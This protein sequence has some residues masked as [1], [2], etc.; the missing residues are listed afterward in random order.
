M[1]RPPDKEG[2][3]ALS[4]RDVESSNAT[5][6]TLFGGSRQKSWMMGAGTPV[7]PTPRTSISKASAL[8]A[9]LA[10]KSVASVLPSPA[11]SDEASPV[12]A[13][14][15]INR[16][17]NDTHQEVRNGDPI[18]PSTTTFTPSRQAASEPVIEPAGG[19]PPLDSSSGPG[20]SS[21]RSPN[22]SRR[23]STNPPPFTDIPETVM[24]IP[25]LP[26]S[27]LLPSERQD[28]RHTSQDLNSPRQASAPSPVQ[29]GTPTSQYRTLPSPR[30]SSVSGLG[31]STRPA[32]TQ[33]QTNNLDG[34]QQASQVSVDTIHCVNEG[35]VNTSSAARV[36]DAR[37]PNLAQSN[38]S[39][40][41][42]STSTT[43]NPNKR[44]RTQVNA[45][46]SLKGRVSLI[47]K[48]IASAGGLQNLNT[49]LER[50]RFALLTDACRNEDPF[51]VALHQVFCVW[52]LNQQEVIIIPGYP[53]SNI[54]QAAF[55]ILGALIRDN[56]Q[57]APVHKIWFAQFP[58]PLG[59]LL[60]V[61][62]VYRQSI[63]D[64][65]VF[66]ERLTVEWVS[67]STEW[68]QR[69]YPP[70]VDELVSRLGLLSPTLQSV[71]FTAT[72]RNLGIRDED[73][74]TR[75]E[76]LFRRD[77]Q[78][79]QALSARVNTAR[80]PTAK[81]VQERNTALVNEYLTLHNHVIQR[82]SS[83]AISGSPLLRGPTPVLASNAPRPQ[84][85]SIPH[86]TSWQQDMPGPDPATTWQS[87]A[88]N[89]QGILRTSNGPPNPSIAGRPPSVGSQQ[90][91][92]DTPSPTLLQGLSMNSP[93]QQGFP[94][95]GSG[96]NGAPVQS[97]PQYPQGYPGYIVNGT[98]QQQSS[99]IDPNVYNRN[100]NTVQYQQQLLPQYPQPQ[101]PQY[102]TQQY[103]PAQG[104]WPQHSVQIQHA[105]MMRQQQQRQLEQQ[106]FAMHRAAQLRNES[107]DPQQ[108][109]VRNNS[110]SS[111]GRRTPTG[112]PSPRISGPPALGPGR[113]M[114]NELALHAYINK[115]PLQRSIVPP[116]GFTHTAFPALPDQVA[117]HQAHLRSPRLVAADP[118]PPNI[119]TDSPSLRHYQAIR[120]FALPP[121]RIS[122]STPLSKFDF[123]PSEAELAMIAQ[124]IPHS[125]GQ[126]SDRQY[127]RGTLQY[128]VR[129][130]QAKQA[131]VKCSIVEW[132]LK[133]TVWPEG[134]ALSINKKHLELRRKNH[135]GKDLA[136]DITPFVRLPGPNMRSQISLSI[137]RG[138][139]KMKEHGYFLGV[140]V[141]E[142]LQHDQI[143]DMVRKNRISAT[144]SLDKI[145]RS[146]AGP[147]DEDD[148]IAM[149]ISDI[150][151]DLA[152]PFTARIF[153]TPVRGVSCLHRECFDL[154]TFLL[155]RNS[156][157]KRP[158]Q[159]CMIDVWKCPLCGK[160]ARPY[161]LQIDDF[162][163]SVRQTLEARGNLDVK[164]IWVGGEG[165]WRPKIEKRKAPPDPNDSDD[166]DDQGPRKPSLSL[167]Q[168]GETRPNRVVEV[169]SLVSCTLK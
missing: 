29:F 159:P 87:A 94:S 73:V 132:V 168:S 10:Q 154:E 160:D 20:S 63:T 163:V 50:P 16:P 126:I 35:L 117:L 100:V 135:H 138:R 156:K 120:G 92:L 121:T 82:R 30:I 60:V 42:P 166:S 57:L 36:G 115:P 145:K 80:P 102:S 11:P 51:Y 8:P 108:P 22:H 127:H 129:C 162:L 83:T 103:Q 152:D 52:D 169:I 19:A 119:P 107:I 122:I 12:L 93:V 9:T 65:G 48:H 81:E 101:Q 84:S 45:M 151:I 91:H 97:N 109:H 99:N 53:N 144:S 96:R 136:I 164:A 74:G 3:S 2:Q 15:T 27:V 165:N 155:T 7:R 161:S 38:M 110:V 34:M 158:G 69:G 23:Q 25:P 128:R 67:L 6:N 95:T 111:T 140:E 49:G 150:S 124:D 44:Q 76:D 54:L 21:S 118:P 66:L 130:V 47:E 58:G 143:L 70:L 88:Q 146:L 79:H 90:M 123:R 89:H 59:Q 86:P 133:D 139:T 113:P 142:I 46:P 114:G 75:M 40:P 37:S 77:Q 116:F 134:A 106:A 131:A 62:E 43:S 5:L 4:E 61:S 137:L 153:D 141:V 157:P 28:N 104:S 148:D 72:R 98:V 31:I 112:R 167:H 64:V 14:S 1:R 71:V 147:I 26:S 56:D 68:T 33:Q 41:S 85:N 24:E 18:F 55:K 149:V 13:H 105:A 32:S 125:N 17:R 39:Y 78:E